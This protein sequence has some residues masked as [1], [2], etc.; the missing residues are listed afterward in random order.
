LV[1]DGAMWRRTLFSH[2]TID[3]DLPALC[4]WPVNRILLS[5]AHGACSNSDIASLGHPAGPGQ[6]QRAWNDRPRT[7]PQTR[8]AAAKIAAR[9]RSRADRGVV[10]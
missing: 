4:R 2:L 7:A 1:I 3:R 10:A 9:G 6:R 8:H 5:A